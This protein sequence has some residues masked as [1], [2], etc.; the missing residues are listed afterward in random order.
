MKKKVAAPAAENQI[1]HSERSVIPPKELAESSVQILA[2]HKKH[3]TAAGTS[4]VLMC[5]MGYDLCRIKDGLPHGSWGGFQATLN[6]DGLSYTTIKRYMQVWKRLDPAKAKLIPKSYEAVLRG[7]E[8]LELTGEKVTGLKLGGGSV[9]A[10]Y[11]ELGMVSKPAPKGDATGTEGAT[12]DPEESPVELPV[13]DRVLKLA[14]IKA[15]RRF[16]QDVVSALPAPAEVSDCAEVDL[17]EKWLDAL[18]PLTSFAAALH[19]RRSS[20]RT[21]WQR[22]KLSAQAAP[23]APVLAAKPALL[24]PCVNCQK[25]FMAVAGLA[26]SQPCPHCGE[27]HSAGAIT[28]QVMLMTELAAAETAVHQ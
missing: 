14:D 16:W 10:V 2:A 5:W 6:L 11:R 13:E 18:L 17:L 1:A 8:K 27:P 21:A 24:I 26:N 25:S 4:V 15:A 28:T 23:P 3:F 22:K 7:I 12:A 9:T 20:L 19:K